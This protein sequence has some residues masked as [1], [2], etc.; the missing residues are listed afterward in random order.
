MKEGSVENEKYEGEI[1]REDRAKKEKEG[2]RSKEEAK[3]KQ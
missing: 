3:D 2:K 1:M